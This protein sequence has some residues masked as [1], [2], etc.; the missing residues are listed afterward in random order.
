MDYQTLFRHI[1]AR[2]ER[3]VMIGTDRWITSGPAARTA[4]FRGRI[5]GCTRTFRESVRFFSLA[6]R[7]PDR[8]SILLCCTTQP[9]GAFCRKA[10]VSRL[11]RPMMCNKLVFAT[12]RNIGPLVLI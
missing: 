3:A 6:P 4:A 1:N 8:R 9:R 2:K 5:H 12:L 10:N 11:S 7:A